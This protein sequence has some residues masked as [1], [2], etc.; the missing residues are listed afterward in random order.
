MPSV[1][2]KRGLRANLPTSNLRAGELHLTTDRQTA[3]FPTDGTTMVPIV[4]AIDDLSK[5][6]SITGGEDLL[7]I[8]DASAAGVKEKRITFNDFKDALSIPAGSTDEKVAVVA[9]GAPGFLWGTDGTD[10][11]LRVNSSMAWTKGAGD[12]FVT[13][14]VGDIDCGTF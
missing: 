10:G 11:V 14:A 8:H 1:S 3:H 2:H 7:I 9:G 12:G 6:A 4:P 13:L 5:L